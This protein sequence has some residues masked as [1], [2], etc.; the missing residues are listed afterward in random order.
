MD[1]WLNHK[2]LLLLLY[3]LIT[4]LIIFFVQQIT[5]FLGWL[6][7]FLKAVLAP[8]LIAVIISYLLNPVVSLLSERKVPRTVAILVIYALFIGSVTV[9]MMNIIPMFI[10][11]LKELNEHLPEM[12]AQTQKM[13]QAVYENRNL[14]D[15]I[16][17][18]LQTSLY[19]LEK[20]ISGQISRFLNRLGSTINTLLI[21]FI[22]PFLAFYML[23]DF[24]LLERTALTI[25]P[26]NKR[27]GVV[28][29]LVEIDRA[30]GSYV[31]GQMI[32]CAVVGVLAY[33][34]YWLIGMPYP[35][36][37]AGIVAVF[38]IVPYLGPYLGAAPA[39]VM[40]ATVSLR[41]VIMVAIVNT[42]CQ[43]LEGNVISPQI[44]GKT[45]HMHP[46][47]II[48]VLLVGGELAGILGMILAV[49]LFAALKVV[50]HHLFVYYVRRNPRN[51]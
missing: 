35:L 9:I 39:I 21:A 16:K 18:G 51:P 38:N 41:M 31:R 50:V 26:R 32:V 25:V 43:V 17:E 7:G 6:F 11:Q 10:A 4:V 37:F 40:A 24:K 12:T 44:V 30:L 36:L 23:K 13:L 29:L 27:K 45:L 15:S 48:F 33:I 3:T 8:F 49:P 20:S 47:T 28:R 1:K 42:V 34:G 2:G 19:N 14:P 46:L 5:P 22:I